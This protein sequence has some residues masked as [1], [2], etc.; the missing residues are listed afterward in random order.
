MCTVRNTIVCRLL[1]S[2]IKI[3]RKK[4]EPGNQEIQGH[5]EESLEVLS[6]EIYEF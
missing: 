2:L 1:R 6:R 3:L 5:P 4:R